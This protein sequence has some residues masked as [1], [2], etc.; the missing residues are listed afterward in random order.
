[1]LLFKAEGRATVRNTHHAATELVTAPCN[2]RDN[3]GISA[4]IAHLRPA[5]EQ[6]LLVPR[7]IEPS[8]R[9]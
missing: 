9:H 8:F 6:A 2:I 5:V 4:R 1:M 7:N 3:G